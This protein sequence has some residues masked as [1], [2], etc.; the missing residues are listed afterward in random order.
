MHKNSKKYILFIFAALLT[1]LILIPPSRNF[2]IQSSSATVSTDLSEEEMRG[3]WVASIINLDYPLSPTTSPD[4]LRSQADEIIENIDTWGF[5]TIFLQVRPCSDALYSSKIYPWSSYLTGK[6][7]TAP[8]SGF[9]PLEYWITESHKRGIELH[10]WINPLRIT[11]A[12]S[13][14]DSLA[15]DSPARLHPEWVITYND[16]FYFDPALPQ[17]RQLVID[18]VIELAENYDIDGI[19]MDD[20]FYPGS[21]FNDI[22]SY[23]IYGKDFSDSGDW[24]RNNINLL[25]QNM[26]TA[27]HDSDPDI[28]FGISPSGVWADKSLNPAGSDT[29]RTLSS[30]YELYADTKYWVEEGWLDYIAPQL[31]WEVGHEQADFAVLLDWWADVVAAS[32]N[33]TKLY[34]GLADSNTSEATSPDNPWYN[35]AEIARQLNACNASLQVSGTIHFRY[36]FIAE[37][38]NLQEIICHAYKNDE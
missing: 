28:K 29:D 11:H 37:D 36:R 16:N 30:Y 27:L 18:G 23:E 19:H 31:Y 4:E 38:P 33:N 9:D 3:I 20:Y 7:G 15:S 6:Q 8:D 24:R 5:N 12:A 34:I 25:I 32:E 14:W 13:E 17:V 35:G 2:Y 10:A 1:L 21:D 22:S 26:S